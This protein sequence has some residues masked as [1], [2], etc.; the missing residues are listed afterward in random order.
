MKIE[1]INLLHTQ[2]NSRI[3]E[4]GILTISRKLWN[5]TT[6]EHEKPKPVKTRIIPQNSSEGVKASL[7][8]Y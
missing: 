8:Y 4:S 2:S 5:K 7:I 1:L 6:M 3:L